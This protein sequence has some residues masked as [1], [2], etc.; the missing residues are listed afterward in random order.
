MLMNVHAKTKM[1]E[2]EKS[3]KYDELDEQHRKGSQYII[4]CLSELSTRTLQVKVTHFPEFCQ[5]CDIIYHTGSNFR[6]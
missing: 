6:R 2:I 1:S 4:L 3:Q 5:S